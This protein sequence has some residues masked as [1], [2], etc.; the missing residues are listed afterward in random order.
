MYLIITYERV[1]FFEKA[2]KDLDTYNSNS[3]YLEIL[4][5]Y[6]FGIKYQQSKKKKLEH[7]YMYTKQEL[8]TQMCVG[9]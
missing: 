3:F 9:T 5:N 8:Y 6:F 4:I 7:E 2:L 1:C